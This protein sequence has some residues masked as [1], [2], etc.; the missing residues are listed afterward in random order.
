MSK[1]QIPAFTQFRWNVIQTF[2]WEGTNLLRGTLRY[3]EYPLKSAKVVIQYLDQEIT[4]WVLLVLSIISTFVEVYAYVRIELL[5]DRIC[6][7]FSHTNQNKIRTHYQRHEEMIM[8]Q[9]SNSDK[10]LYR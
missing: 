7:V 3:E 9:H 10:T 8:T 2:Q 5:Y 4:A 6:R 1:H